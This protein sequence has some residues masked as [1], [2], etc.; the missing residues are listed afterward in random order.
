[1]PREIERKFLVTGD[2][3]RHLSKGTYYQQGYLST[4]KERSIRIRIANGK[5]YL[6]IK[7]ISKGA[8]R[9]EYEYE[10]PVGD[11]REM[12]NDLCV[13]PKIEKYRYTFDHKGFTWEVDEFIGDNE[14]LVI[15]E[16]ELDTEDQ[17][18]IKPEWIGEEITHDPRYYNVNLIA[19][20]FSRWKG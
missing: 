4:V 19:N 3:Y 18:F 20:P 8:T 14:G 1:M 13:K 12:L 9:K 10:I 11:A 15:A 6:T 16:I 7:G 17:I 5:G 2:H